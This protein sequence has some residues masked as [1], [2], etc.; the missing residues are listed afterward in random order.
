M[1]ELFERDER[2][3]FL[4]TGWKLITL[5]RLF[6]SM[7][8]ESLNKA[9][10]S[11]EDYSDRVRFLAEQTVQMTGLKD[12]GVYLSRLLTIDALFL[13]EDRHTHNI[14]VLLDD[15][16]VYHYCPVFDNGAALLSD[17]AMDYP[18][19]EPVA[20]LMEEVRARTIC[21]DWVSEA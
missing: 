15:M 14:A 1:I 2:T 18:M 19:S 11:I 16:G 5:E 8:G 9:V 12:F 20:G 4:P 13:N 10:Y 21:C 7:C 3:D 17:T 6:Q